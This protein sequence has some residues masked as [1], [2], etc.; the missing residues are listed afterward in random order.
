[1]TPPPELPADYSG[2]T[3]LLVNP[4]GTLRADFSGHVHAQG[5]DLDTDTVDPASG[6]HQVRWLNANGVMVAHLYTSDLAGPKVRLR[7]L[8]YPDPGGG[9]VG[10]KFGVIDGPMGAAAHAAWIECNH[11]PAANPKRTVYVRA[12]DDALADFAKKLLDSNGGS[13]FLIHKACRVYHSADQAIANA[14]V[15]QLAF[16]SE[17]FDTDAIHDS[18]VNNDRLTAKTAGK[19]V[20]TACVQFDVAAGG[21]RSLQLRYNGIGTVIGVQYVPPAAANPVIG[22]VTTIYDLAVGDYVQVWVYQTSGG[23]LNVQAAPNYSPEFSMSRI[24]A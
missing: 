14:A 6:E 19:Y 2:D 20:I 22:T 3:V 10:S 24:A 12:D 16:D 11:D 17:R 5:L 8:G 21:I 4:D 18:A 15:T 7:G 13:D 23:A 1:V 9:D